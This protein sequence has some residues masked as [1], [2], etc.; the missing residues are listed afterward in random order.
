[1]AVEAKRGP[2][3]PLLKAEFST[4]SITEPTP[5][6]PVQPAANDQFPSD[7]QFHRSWRW[8]SFA[9]VSPGR[10]ITRWPQGVSLRSISAY[11]A[12]QYGL[13]GRPRR[14]GKHRSTRANYFFADSVDEETYSQ[15]FDIISPDKGA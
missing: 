4:T 2:F 11:Q 14:H 6:E 1:V 7:G 9:R 10:S 5:A 3:R 15:E 13:P 12:G 8:T